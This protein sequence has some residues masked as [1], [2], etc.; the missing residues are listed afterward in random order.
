MTAKAEDYATQ[1]LME[2]CNGDQSSVRHGPMCR[3][4]GAE[5]EIQKTKARRTRRGNVD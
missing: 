1:S 3:L 5:W 2:T 4:H